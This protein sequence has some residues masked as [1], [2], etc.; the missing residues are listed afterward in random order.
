[1]GPRVKY[2]ALD[3]LKDREYAFKAFSH[4]A[5]P[6]GPS[7]GRDVQWT[8]DPGCVGFKKGFGWWLTIEALMMVVLCEIST[9]A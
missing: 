6:K 4:S 3:R 7:Q 2:T 8:P 1:M 9:T 5:S